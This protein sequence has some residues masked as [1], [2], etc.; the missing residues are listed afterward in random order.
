MKILKVLSVVHVSGGEVR[1]HFGTDNCKISLNE[2]FSVEIQVNR[3]PDM[4]MW[5][6]GE[7]AQKTD[8]INFVSV[9]SKLFER[10][11]ELHVRSFE[12][13]FK[14]WG[15]ESSATANFE[16]LSTKFYEAVI[17]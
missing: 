5:S 10:A 13:G 6:A 14:K 11:N 7:F 8:K 2:D 15:I 4:I 9:F 17:E 12:D 1:K 16:I 3:H